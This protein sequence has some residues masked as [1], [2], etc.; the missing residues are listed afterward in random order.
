MRVLEISK[1]SAAAYAGLLLAEL[2][3]EVDRLP[4]RL[5]QPH[6]DAQARQARELFF[7]R[8]KRDVDP[9]D[10]QLT[11]YDAVIEDIGARPLQRL[12]L[13]YRKIRSA[14]PDVQ[15]ISL[16]D[17]GATGPYRNWQAN[18]INVQ[19][20]GGVMHVSGFAGDTPRK[21]PDDAAAMIAGI[22]GATAACA[23]VFGLASGVESGNHVDISAQDTMMQHWA[24]HVADYA[25]SGATLGRQPHDP[26]G[27]HAHHTARASDGWVFMLALRQPWQD[28][29]AFLGL[30]DL[31]PADS[32]GAE[33]PQPPWQTIVEPFEAAVAG[34]S[35]YQWFAE[36][37]ELGWTFAPVETAHA[38]LHGPQ[39]RARQATETALVDGREVHIPGLP[40]RR[41]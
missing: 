32:M 26:E 37:A 9:A 31:I 7:Q 38:V 21:L 11:N 24:R 40:H 15:L 1:H 36:A 8:G 27:I 25:Y 5:A 12:G 10:L 14:H 34:K 22:H 35:R 3:F 23:G 6:I 39:T 18:D 19:A 20:A 2:G 13:S 17:F 4:L 33:D 41:E 16:S 29:A 28:V 30:G